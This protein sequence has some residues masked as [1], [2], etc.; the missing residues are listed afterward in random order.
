MSS[1][2]PDLFNSSLEYNILYGDPRVELSAEAALNAAD[3]EPLSGE[4]PSASAGA[5][6]GNAASSTEV[7]ASVLQAAEVCAV[8]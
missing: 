3:E 5:G 8:Y 2:E 1:Q 7:P 6:S 4:E